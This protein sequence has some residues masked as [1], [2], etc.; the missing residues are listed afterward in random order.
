MSWNFT[1]SHRGFACKGGP[2]LSQ[3]CDSSK[4]TATGRRR[5]Y[6][7]RNTL[8][9]VVADSAALEIHYFWPSQICNNPSLCLTA[10]RIG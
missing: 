6:N 7:A 10:S 5:F 3:I 1:A 2:A 4:Y 8:F 9:L